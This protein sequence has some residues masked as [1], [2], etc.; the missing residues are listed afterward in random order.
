MAQQ[1]NINIF[2]EMK[3]RRVLQFV[4]FY[5]G[6]AW[7]ALEFLGFLTDRYGLSPNIL[8]LILLS[9]GTMLPSVMV[10]AY[11]HGKPGRDRWT[12]ADK[13]VIPMNMLVTLGLIAFFFGG[14]DLSATTITVTAE[15]E[16]GATIE[17]TIPKATYRKRIC[18]YF[19]DN[20]T[21]K[22]TD[23]W[24]GWWLPHAIYLDLVQDYYFDNRDPFQ[25]SKALTEAGG[26]DEA[27][28][29][30]L[31]QTTTR[32]FHLSHFLEGDVLSVNPFT[33]E[34]RLYLTKGGR[35]VASH[36]YEGDGLGA[37][38]D[39]ITLDIKED[40]GLSA[41]KIEQAQDLP[42]TALT[43][44]VPEAIE[45]YINGLI[46]V[47]FRSDW[48]EAGGYFAQA[49]EL[50]PTFA[51]AQLYLYEASLFSDRENGAAIET[52]MRHIYKI[53]ER[54]QGT[55]KEVYYFWKGEPVKALAAL[56]LDVNLFSDDVIAQRRLARFYSRM[57]Q[58]EDAL[59]TYRVILQLNPDDD[60]ILLD[61][62]ETHTALGQFTAALDN[63]NAYARGNPR[64]GEVLVEIGGVY[65]ILGK[66]AEA[67]RLY[68]RAIL[69]GYN[70]GEVLIHQADVLFQQGW[71]DEA[72]Q[73][74]REGIETAQS[75]EAR[76]EALRTLERFLESLGRIQE[77]M[78]VSRQAMPLERQVYGPLNSIILRLDH[79]S[80]YAQTTLADSVLQ[81]MTQF[82]DDLPEPWDQ[83]YD[84]FQVQYKLD[85]GPAG[86]PISTEDQALVELFY[87]E[88]KF[89]VDV[90]Y[91]L[92]T[93]R[94][95]SG[96]SDYLGA[97][98]G[99]ITTLS[100]YPRRVM[101]QKDIAQA[102][103]QLGDH[104]AA[105]TT[106]DQLLKVYPHQPEVIY[107]LYRVQRLADPAA[108][109]ETLTR[110]ADSWNEADDI[111]LPAREIRQ[112]M[113]EREAL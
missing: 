7:V 60:L 99:F 39:R 68:D 112:A 50:D 35:Q 90:P 18:L 61:I 46:Q 3:E 17:R 10:F 93:A 106:I 27:I 16:T 13:I 92:I 1:S 8:D 62:A 2:R 81:T 88:Y 45:P 97:I 72:M 109:N 24:V 79:F 54:L 44:D 11:N 15:D 102:Y 56:R 113:R 47:Y 110:L 69:L 98:Q 89:L 48:I 105:L 57:G 32:R 23:D 19:F 77:A 55:I 63:L 73:R 86:G 59:E 36:R 95:K 76:L 64:D 49:V 94:I 6:G 70:R 58:Y 71:F 9:L 25:L 34:T 84:V 31:M 85:K 96:N 80:K 100:R 87:S 37:V 20:K 42:I 12:R 67:A 107:E 26:T 28:P 22:S 33:I 103:R 38:I 111:Y 52:A 66:T 29:L 82:G 78:Q 91:E 40:M 104:E 14:K 21:G 43:S 74:A 4:G 75:P 51:Q 108:A 101:I 41:A 53:P 30:A 83:A 5:M 65:Q